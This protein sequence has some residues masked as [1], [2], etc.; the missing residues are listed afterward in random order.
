M[1]TAFSRTMRSL[2]AD[3]FRRSIW[4]V[5]LAACFLGAWGAWCLYAHVTLY[6]ITETARIEVDSAI[7]PIQSPLVGRVVETNLQIGREVKAGDVLVVVDAEPQLLQ[8]REERTR[9]AGL[10]NELTALRGQVEAEDRARDD[11]QQ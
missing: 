6:E 4:G 7:Y 8:I 9:L 5:F 2:G 10:D 1:S 3:R 11:E